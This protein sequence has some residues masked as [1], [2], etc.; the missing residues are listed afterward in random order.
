MQF[1]I[2]RSWLTNT[3]SR[4]AFYQVFQIA[5]VD[6]GGA[7]AGRRV[8]VAH[9]GKL[10]GTEA[11]A[12]PVLGGNVKVLGVGYDEAIA[13]K[14][15]GDYRF[16]GRKDLDLRGLDMLA[17]YLKENFGA[18]H[19]HAILSAMGLIAAG[20]SLSDDEPSPPTDDEPIPLTTV[21]DELD[22]ELME[23][24]EPGRGSW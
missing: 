17:R 24:L 21:V 16:H 2:Q 10:S 6:T 4:N 19:A 14:T 13:A 3:T 11:F 8:V 18:T 12:R 23:L 1:S 20:I 7:S 15:K 9:Y 5:G 22:A